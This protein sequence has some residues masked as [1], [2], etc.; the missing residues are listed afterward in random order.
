M[1]PGRMKRSLLRGPARALA[2]CREPLMAPGR[3]KRSLLRGPARALA[4]SGIA[5]TS[6]EEIQ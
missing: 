5:L 2:H 4:H 6:K 3:M 1:A